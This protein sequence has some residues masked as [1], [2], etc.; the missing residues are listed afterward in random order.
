LTVNKRQL[1][2]EEKMTPNTAE[3]RLTALE[4]KLPDA[5][6]PAAVYTNVVIARGLVFVAGKGPQ[7]APS[8]KLGDEFSTSEGYVFAR[9]AGIQILSALNQALGS[10][11]QIKRVV[12][13][14]GFVNAT[15]DF[16]EHHMVLNGC[17]ELM[18]SVF[19]DSGIHARSVLG[20]NSLRD[21]LPVIIESIFEIDD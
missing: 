7:G 21:N 14:Q 2:Q 18:V 19:G 15:A 1:E 3:E 20:A 12:K 8:G 5:S 6:P 9:S 11:N 16:Q 4:I 13:L 10:I 17:S